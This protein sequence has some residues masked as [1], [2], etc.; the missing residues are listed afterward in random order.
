MGARKPSPSNA[1][2]SAVPFSRRTLLG[3]A[4]ALGL[5]STLTCAG[6]DASAAAAA[7]AAPR[8]VIVE[9][10][11]AQLREH[12]IDDAKVPAIEQL[13]RA[14]QAAGDYDRLPDGAEFAK[15]ITRDMQSIGH[16]GHLYLRYRSQPLAPDAGPSE[17]AE[18]AAQRNEDRLLNYG[19]S[20]AEW[21]PG[22]IG[23]LRV[24]QF[25]DSDGGG[26]VVAG[27]MAMLAHT[28]AMILDLRANRG[29]GDLFVVLA[30][31]FLP[32]Q[33][34]H[35][36]TLEYPR[37]NESIQIWSLP[38]VAGPR[39]LDRPVYVL[40]SRQTFSAGEAFAYNLQAA[41]RIKVVGERTRGGADPNM[42]TSVDP[43]FSLSI[44]IGRTVHPVTKTSWEGVGVTP[45]VPTAT[46]DDALDAALALATA[47]L[48]R[49]PDKTGPVRASGGSE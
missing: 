20:R 10:I 21:L 26:R 49:Q 23:Y 46:A 19:L 25:G 33:P 15:A 34:Q 35:L 11:L 2:A 8:A 32:P 39:Y 48:R 28:D 1:S 30:S 31:Y 5:A 16:S 41:G 47:E 4:I 44:P 24:N 12:Y 36:S 37:R 3:R 42:V 7:A 9:A 6:L 22:N 40:I 27:A 17:A 14:R 18:R 43:H 38:S 45:D 29:G 13:L